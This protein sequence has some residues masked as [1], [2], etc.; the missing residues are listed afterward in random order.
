MTF[1]VE[2]VCSE[3]VKQFYKHGEGPPVQIFSN[4]V[5]KQFSLRFDVFIFPFV[6]LEQANCNTFRL[7]LEFLLFF[8]IYIL[9]LRGLDHQIYT[10][11]MFISLNLVMLHNF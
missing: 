10:V 9:M 4:V 1:V 5:L 11:I 3:F 2:H 8:G 7:F 6:A